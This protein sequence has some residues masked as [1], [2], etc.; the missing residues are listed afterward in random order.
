MS[1]E[2]IERSRKIIHPI[3]SSEGLE[4]VDLEYRREA[5]GWILRLYIDKE[6]GITLDDCARINREVGRMLDVENS[7]DTP[8]TLEVSS[9]G[10]TR[11]LKSERDFLKYQNRLIK[12]KTV[13]PVGNQRQFKGRLL[14]VIHE[15]IE[16]DADGKVVHIPFQNIAKANLVL[17]F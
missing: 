5:R 4:Y 17:E 10:L 6:G 11:P 14:K 3:L 1:E 15:G 2:I 8:Y 13:E 16:I 9:P 7:I 12:V